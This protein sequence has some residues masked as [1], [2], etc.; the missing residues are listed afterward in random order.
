MLSSVT[1]INDEA[2][3]GGGSAPS[4]EE[5]R[6]SAIGYINAQRRIVTSS[7]YEKR[8][9][10][11]PAKYGSVDKAFVVKDD[12]INSIVKFTKE[13]QISIDSLDPED[14]VDYVENNPI[15]TNINLYVLGLNSDGRLTTM[16]NTVKSNIKQ[17]LKGYRMMTDRINIVDA[18]RVSIGVDYSIIAYTGFNTS[19][20]LARC[21]D[22]VRK[23]FNIDNWQINQP[24]IKDDLLVQIAKVDGVQAVPRLQII[25]KYQQQHGSDYATYS[26]NLNANTT[27]GVI[28]PS[29]DPC[30][31]EL[32]YPQTDITGTATQ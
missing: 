27:D 4:I 31:F 9:L 19:D 32:R 28:Y 2:A 5:I 17:F 18:F 25:N 7:D 29:A 13:E 1:V 14:D 24:I 23:Y 12:A 3:S 21:H 20:V 11:M 8:V 16:N 15:N 26:Y 6:Q 22:T 10:S 30:I